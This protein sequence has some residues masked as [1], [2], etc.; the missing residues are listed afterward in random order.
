MPLFDALAA[1]AAHDPDRIAIDGLDGAPVTY[2]DL[3][4]FLADKSV[5][6]GEAY[7]PD[8][9]VALQRDHGPAT[10]ILELALLHARL[11][12]LSL[13]SFFT[14][15][16]SQH[17][18]ALC[19]AMPD[20]M[21]SPKGTARSRRSAAVP[22]PGGTAR[23]TFTSGSTGTPKG[24]CLS[25]QHMFAV[26]GSVVE[27]VGAEHAGRHLALLPPGILLET[28]AGF[29]PTLLAGGTYVCPPQA[30]IGLAD[31]FRP[32]F[33]KAAAVIAEQRITSLILVP[34]YLEALVRVMEETG[35][36]LP[37]L[38]LV[39]VGGARTSIPLMDRARRLGLPVRQGY[40]LTE[41]ASVVSLQRKGDDDPASVGRC[42]PHM[43]AR[44]AD[45]GEIILD[46]PLCLGAIGGEAPVSP[47]HTGDIG[48]IDED[49]RLHIEGRKSNLIVT[50]FGRNISPEWVEA[51]LV[52]QPAIAQALVYGDGL[53]TPAALVVPSHPDADLAAA[54]AAANDRLP[55]YARI[56]A[57]REAAHFTPMNGQLTGNGRLRRAAIA[58][59]YLDRQPDFFTRLEAQTVRER[60]RFLTIP[61]LQAGLNGTITRSAY[62]SYLAQA[63]HHV[64]HTV[65]L[66]QAARARLA[67]RADIVAALDDYIAEETGHEEWILSD[68]AVA[69]GDAEQVRTSAPAPATAAMVAH[70][71]DRI[72]NGN[73]MAFFGMVYVLESVSVAL[74][75][76]GASAVA[77]NLGLPPQAFTYLTSHGAL[78]QEH[79]AFFARLVNGL[80]DPAD[81]DAI[82]TMAKEMFGLFGGVF[83]SVEL[84]DTHASA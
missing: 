81:R 68:I 63:Y 58:A 18:L 17:A 54:I 33:A 51:A 83:A 46:G 52:E 38:T 34:E 64:R 65:P 21:K 70:A 9:P 42:L 39:A 30:A 35:L 16:Q 11:P 2:G 3:G 72:A 5:E 22:L 4:R 28:V 82:L 20:P 74:A 56:G 44:I 49:G 40:G 79:M 15:D 8:T 75:T 48:S 27:A 12:V 43:A 47:F 14:R 67:G 45:D 71:Y 50:S 26:A 80:A 55:A 69:G 19:G 62:L 60:L 76:R 13:P 10:A 84:E 23:I 78:D 57:W 24:I 59:A 53:P 41:C 31:P 7:P 6:L 36:G 32:D 66:M 25:A 37:D 61:Q 1:R 73:A 77:K 29:F